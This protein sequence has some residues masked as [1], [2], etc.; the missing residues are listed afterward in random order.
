M[1][2]KEELEIEKLKL[3]I[4]E[5]KNKDKKEKKKFEKKLSL[6]MVLSPLFLPKG[7]G[8]W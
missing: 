8:E 3:E 5:L 4:E 2:Q 6:A 7:E 1:G